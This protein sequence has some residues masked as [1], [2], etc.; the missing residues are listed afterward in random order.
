MDPV[1]F[2]REGLADDS[3]RTAILVGL[4]T[5]P[6]T[7]VLSWE[8]AAGDTVVVGGSVSGTPMLLPDSSSAPCIATGGLAEPGS[9][10]ASRPRSGR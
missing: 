8:P 5:I 2:L 7:L 1:R 4:A 10:P 6:F 9:G 3:L